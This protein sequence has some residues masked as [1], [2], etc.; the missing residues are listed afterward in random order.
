MAAMLIAASPADAHARLEG[1]SP[2]DGATLSAVPPEVM[3]RF[4]EP[5]QEDLNQVSV[6][7]GSTEVAKGDPQVDGKKVYQPVE[8][9]MEPGEYTITYKVVSADGHPVSGSLS[10]TYAPPEGDGKVEE[11]SEATPYS[12]SETSSPAEESSETS[13]PAEPSETSGEGGEESPSASATAEDEGSDVATESVDETS[14]EGS[15]P[16]WWAL[17]VGALA[18]VVGGLVM[19]V[20]GR[21][22]SEDGQSPRD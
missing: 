2:Q 4:N 21:R 20:R 18:V 5:I 12:P 15:S 9:T 8:Y 16:W 13:S 10:F 6:K 1:S 14:Q 17:A 7:S 19:L 11:D 22:D 3:L